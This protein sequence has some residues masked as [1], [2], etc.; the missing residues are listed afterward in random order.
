MWKVPCE[1][2]HHAVTGHLAPQALG[3]HDCVAALQVDGKH[4]FV[5]GEP[6]RVGR[7]ACDIFACTVHT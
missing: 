1:V 3:V 5:Y 4:M 6:C 7:H 2:Q